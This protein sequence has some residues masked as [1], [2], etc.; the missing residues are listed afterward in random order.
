VDSVSLSWPGNGKYG[1]VVTA[2]Y[3]G[4][5]L[6]ASHSIVIGQQPVYLPVIRRPGP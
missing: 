5:D 3:S 1:L 6:T 2:R 4:G